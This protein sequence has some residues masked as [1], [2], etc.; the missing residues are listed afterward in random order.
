MPDPPGTQSQRIK[1]H[2]KEPEPTPKLKLS[3]GV[4]RSA[5]EM[6][7]Y[8]VDTEALKRQKQLVLD[9][10]N[11]RVGQSS[12]PTPPAFAREGSSTSAKGE[13]GSTVKLQVDGV[14]GG[15]SFKDVAQSTH[16]TSTNAALGNDL[17]PLAAAMMMPPPTTPF[18]SRPVSQ[19]KPP[20]IPLPRNPFDT[21]RRSDRPEGFRMSVLIYYLCLLIFLGW[22]YRTIYEVVIESHPSLN[23]GSKAY[24]W[25]L[26]PWSDFNYATDVLPLRKESNR[27]LVSPSF[28]KSTTDRPFVTSVVMVN[29]L[30]QY[31]TQ[32]SQPITDDGRPVY[33]LT[34]D[35]K[36]ISEIEVQCL[37]QPT[38]P[39]SLQDIIFDKY[40]AIVHPRPT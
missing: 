16:A 34:L 23:L 11:G 8:S 19:P 13:D 4:K 38:D 9:G 37:T 31:P 14:K 7:N 27:L 29:G 32:D 2:V 26:F 6:N 35:M 40:T 22:P 28:V 25:Q 36:E 20:P 21:W 12:A 1:L 5:E 10:V 24:R 15:Q 39:C 17:Q 30:R 18:G 33:D 3:A